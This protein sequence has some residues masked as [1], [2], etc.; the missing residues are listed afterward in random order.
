MD[1][2]LKWVEV[3]N[4]QGQKVKSSTSNTISVS[5]LTIGIYM[6]RV[7]DQNGRES[8]QKLVKQ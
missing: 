1:S 8:I 2:E 6:I 7:E 3:Y 4:L 5:D